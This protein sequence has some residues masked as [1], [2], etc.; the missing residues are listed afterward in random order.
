[1][2]GTMNLEL[3]ASLGADAVIDYTKEHAPF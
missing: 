1:V 2:C 3:V